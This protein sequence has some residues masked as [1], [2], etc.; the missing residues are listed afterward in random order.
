MGNPKGQK[1]TTAQTKVLGDIVGYLR[2][3]PFLLITMAGLLVFSGALVFDLDKL[4]EFKSLLYIIVIAPL[5]IQFFIEWQKSRRR[6]APKT[7]VHGQAPA[8]I[9]AN[10]TLKYSGKAIAGAVLCALVF[11]GFADTPEAELMD[12]ELQTGFLVFEIAALV[13]GIMAWNDIRHQRAH[14]RGLAISTV[15]TAGIFML[16]SIGWMMQANG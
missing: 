7:I 1:D 15:V 11:I 8:P 14:G 16:S 4:K 5:V 9:V 6:H 3:Y 10:G 12:S 2:N 13:L